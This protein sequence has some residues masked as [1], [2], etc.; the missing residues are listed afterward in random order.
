MI[1]KQLTNAQLERVYDV[2]GETVD[3]VP[4]DKRQLLL[5]KLALALANLVGDPDKVEAAAKAA[6]RDL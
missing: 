2:I 1:P 6:A 4:T 5:A 3:S